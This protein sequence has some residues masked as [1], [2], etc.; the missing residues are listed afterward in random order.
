M[1]RASM[2]N[3]GV[4]SALRQ[5]KRLMNMSGLVSSLKKKRYRIRPSEERKQKENERKKK[6]MRAKKASAF[7]NDDK[8]I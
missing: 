4:E 1:L 7:C 2:K 8:K 3:G 5:L 6:V